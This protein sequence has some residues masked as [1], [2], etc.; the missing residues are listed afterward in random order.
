MDFSFHLDQ[1]Q[2]LLKKQDSSSIKKAL[3]H[4]KKANQITQN[5]DAAKPKTLYFLALGNYVI[6]NI[7]Q[8]YRIAFKAKR[9][10]DVAIEKSVFSMDNMRS[11]LGEDEI[12]ELIGHIT[13]NFPEIVSF[14][15][16][17]D[18]ND[19]NFEKV[20]L[21]YKTKESTKIK[22]QLLIE[23]L[24]QDV[25]FA[26]FIGLSRNGDEL[27]YFDRKKGDVLSY[28]QGYFSS[29]LGHQSIENRALVYKITNNE[30]KDFVDEERYILIERLRL[31]D[32]LFEYKKQANG[33][34]PFSSYV[35]Y[36]SVE[37]LKGF[38]EKKNVKIKDLLNTN[39]IQKE[40]HECFSK[41]Y[42]NRIL[43]LEED[44]LKI[45]DNTVTSLALKWIHEN[46]EF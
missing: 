34:E 21:L 25:L 43:D 20:D 13:E 3:G 32:F 41:K 42:Q 14:T 7:E 9:S 22:S 10:V 27:I 24:P 45:F 33:K 35:D 5:E 2:Q 36:F 29:H 18:E 30:P 28:V 37:V 15:D 6:G 38:T 16:D 31:S 46:C 40:F 19:L 26:T 44:H 8:S 39:Y 1:G 12:D 4:F 11:L 17:F 23:E